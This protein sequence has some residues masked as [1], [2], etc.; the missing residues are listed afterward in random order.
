MYVCCLYRLKDIPSLCFTS[1]ALVKRGG[2]QK[3]DTPVSPR[4]ADA[5][6][7]SSGHRRKKRRKRRGGKKEGKWS[8]AKTNGKRG[9]EKQKKFE[10]RSS[11]PTIPTL[12]LVHQVEVCPYYLGTKPY[13][14]NH[15]Y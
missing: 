6:F 2:D 4:E 14:Y 13:M 11:F 3:A 10:R 9:K 5:L 7:S 1:Q 15:V 12:R 8:K